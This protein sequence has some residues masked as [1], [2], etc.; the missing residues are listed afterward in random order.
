[1]NSS[2]LSSS[3]LI[4]QEILYSNIDLKSSSNLSISRS[5]RL[6]ISP[7]QRIQSL[8]SSHRLETSSLYRLRKKLSSLPLPL[9]EEIRINYE[10]EKD[11]RMRLSQQNQCEVLEMIEKMIRKKI[12][13]LHLDYRKVSIGGYDEGL[14]ERL[15]KTQPGK[16]ISRA[17]F[18]TVIRNVF[19]FEMTLKTEKQLIKLF[20]A[21]DIQ[22][23]NEID[24]RAFLY[25]LA[26]LIHAYEP[27]L[28][29]LKMGYAIFSSVG[30]LEFD[31]TE[32]LKLSTIK[33]MIE[34][35]IIFSS[36]SAL[37]SLVD[38]CWFELTQTDMEAME[39]ILMFDNYF[40]V[41]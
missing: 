13:E 23:R 3:I 20:N 32:K 31:C 21:F 27:V 35:P 11:I 2:S 34:V 10:R 41:Q 22:E 39:V 36:R 4:K 37:R 33:D 18:Y 7:L 6:D 12:L 1:M 28:T 25:Q 9:H 38:D 5:N 29:H 40:H 14:F 26:L 19:Q 16:W 8:H 24:W 30:T 17:Q 15:Y